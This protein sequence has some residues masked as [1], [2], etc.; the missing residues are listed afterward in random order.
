MRAPWQGHHHVV[1][2][3]PHGVDRHR[4]GRGQG[5]GLAGARA[6]T[7]SRAS[8]TRSRTRRPRRRPRRASSRRASTRRRS[9]TSRRR[10][11]RRTAG[12]RRRRTAATTPRRDV[13]DRAHAAPRHVRPWR[14]PTFSCT[15]AAQRRRQ[16]R[17][18]QPGE[19]VLEE[20]EHDEPLG[21]LGPH[22]AALEVVELVVVDRADGR[23]VRAAHVVRPRSRGSGSTPRRRPR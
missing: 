12:G 3:D 4:L 7:S 11:A 17:D 16:R 19:D 22:A 9:R 8:G 20:P 13:A 23:R 14:W 15:D 6:R 18:R 5:L 21:V 2:V 10:G 1:A